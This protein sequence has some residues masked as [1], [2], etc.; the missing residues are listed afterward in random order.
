MGKVGTPRGLSLV[1]RRFGRHVVTERAPDRPGR[2]DRIWRCLCDCGKTTEVLGFTLTNGKS[3]SCGCLRDDASRG[4]AEHGESRTAVYKIW[5]GA[6]RRCS[7][8]K[9]EWAHLYVGR[10]ITM[11]PEFAASYEAFRDE[12]GPR[13]SR[14]HSVDRRDNDRGYEPGNIYWATKKEQ[15]AN[16]RLGQRVPEH[17]E[18][19]A[20]DY[21]K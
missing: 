9:S 12:L 13:P 11:A 17:S 2:T 6:K 8:E 7:E 18:T 5:S 4:R 15:A 1:G 3:Q 16:S 14:L 20:R 21:R 19:L 10:G